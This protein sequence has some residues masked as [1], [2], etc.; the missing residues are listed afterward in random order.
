MSDQVMNQS[1]SDRQLQEDCAA[2]YEALE[3]T[4]PDAQKAIVRH[5]RAALAEINA[6]IRAAREEQKK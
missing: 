3:M 4:R 5:T 2:I 6:E 1:R